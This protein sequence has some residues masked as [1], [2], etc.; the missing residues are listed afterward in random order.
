MKRS[1][2]HFTVFTVAIIFSLNAL[3]QKIDTSP[4]DAYWKMIEPLKQGDSLATDTWQNFLKIESNQ[5]YIENQG[6]DKGYL[7]RL[8]KAIQVVYMPVYDSLLQT[9]LIAIK[10]DPSSYWLT[11]KV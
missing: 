8:R 10:K 6:F 3:C 9:R 11:Y 2:M 5:I 1:L 4:V 7:E